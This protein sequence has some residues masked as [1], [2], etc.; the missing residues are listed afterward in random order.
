[1]VADAMPSRELRGFS[2]PDGNATSRIACSVISQGP[3]TVRR[4]G[5]S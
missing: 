1:M 5:A 3:V 4:L 2:D